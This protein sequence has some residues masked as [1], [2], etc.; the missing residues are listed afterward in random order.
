MN[1][2]ETESELDNQTAACH[3][4]AV[5]ERHT[6]V[7]STMSAHAAPDVFFVPVLISA[8]SVLTLHN[9]IVANTISSVTVL[10]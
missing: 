4:V 10:K 6:V 8:I 2:H 9:D 5:E 7:W 3:K 1:K